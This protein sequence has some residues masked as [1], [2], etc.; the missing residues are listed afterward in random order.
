MSI[1]SELSVRRLNQICVY[2]SFITN[3]IFLNHL[4]HSELL[5]FLENIYVKKYF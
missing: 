2:L 1:Q 5:L 3:L 4:K